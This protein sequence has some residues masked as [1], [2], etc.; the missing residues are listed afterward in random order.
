MTH[1]VWRD[2]FFTMTTKESY[3]S[4]SGKISLIFS[5]GFRGKY[6]SADISSDFGSK[7]KNKLHTLTK[8][9]LEDKDHYTTK[10]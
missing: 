6:F 9:V 2:F 8:I 5:S 4:E 10:K 3:F 7:E 1:S